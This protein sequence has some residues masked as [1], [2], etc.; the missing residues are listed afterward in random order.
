MA[1]STLK[2]DSIEVKIVRDCAKELQEVGKWGPAD[3]GKFEHCLNKEDIK[4]E[5]LERVGKDVITTCSAWGFSRTTTEGGKLGT[6]T[7]KQLLV[8]LE[9]PDGA[10]LATVSGGSQ[11]FTVGH[12]YLMEPL[13]EVYMSENCRFF[14]KN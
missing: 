5:L 6:K 3:L 14:W 12:N 7:R 13:V 2:E 10:Y 8:P 9:V 1:T 11:W 4:Q